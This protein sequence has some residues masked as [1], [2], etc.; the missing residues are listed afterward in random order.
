MEASNASRWLHALNSDNFVARLSIERRADVKASKRSQ[1]STNPSKFVAQMTIYVWFQSNRALNPLVRSRKKRRI[2]I[3]LR[4]AK[5]RDSRKQRKIC[6]SIYHSRDKR[7]KNWRD[8]WRSIQMRSWNGFQAFLMIMRQ[9]RVAAVTV[10]SERGSAH[11][12]WRSFGQVLF[13]LAD[14]ASFGFIAA[15]CWEENRVK[16]L[17][18]ESQ[19]K[20]NKMFL[21][22][23]VDFSS[24]DEVFVMKSRRSRKKLE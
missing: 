23:F 9:E 16:K 21:Q 11:Y 5:T 3:K 20:W 10:S 4:L 19:K 7:N 22:K 17:A 6:I 24:F 13:P 12:L 8:M 15:R 1:T 18:E 2:F 14:E